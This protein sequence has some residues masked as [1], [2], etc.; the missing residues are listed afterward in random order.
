MKIAKVDALHI[1]HL[2]LRF[3]YSYTIPLQFAYSYTIQWITT[4]SSKTVQGQSILDSGPLSRQYYTSTKM[5]QFSGEYKAYQ[6]PRKAHEKQRSCQYGSLLLTSF[7][8]QN[9]FF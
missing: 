2:P 3:A 6:M 8:T 4:K 7:S 5:G 9:S 1:M